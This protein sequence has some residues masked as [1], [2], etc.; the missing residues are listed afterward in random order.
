MLCPQCHAHFSQAPHPKPWLLFYFPRLWMCKRC[1]L[2]TENFGS[3]ASGVPEM[4]QPT[5][6]RASNKP[7]LSEPAQLL[8]ARTTKR[9]CSTLQSM[10]GV[11]GLPVAH[12][13]NSTGSYREKR[14]AGSLMDAL[15]CRRTKR[16]NR[17]IRGTLV[18]CSQVEVRE[19]LRV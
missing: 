11:M 12:L 13:M 18:M 16:H 7:D 8:F 14:R 10:A 1:H 17:G 9:T 4:L 6:I 5:A 19:P 2:R 3:S 15:I